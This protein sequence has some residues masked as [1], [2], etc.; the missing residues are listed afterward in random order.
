[1]MRIASYRIHQS[2]LDK[3]DQLSIDDYWP[4]TDHE[5]QKIEPAKVDADLINKIRKIHNY[6]G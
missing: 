2:L 3:K 5:E 6:N 4:I 1:M